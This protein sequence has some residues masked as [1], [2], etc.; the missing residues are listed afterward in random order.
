MAGIGAHQ[1]DLLSGGLP[2]T[3]EKNCSFPIVQCSKRRKNRGVA[4]WFRG[5]HVGLT[6]DTTA[7]IPTW[8]TSPV[9][10]RARSTLESVVD[11]TLTVARAGLCVQ[12][13]TRATRDGALAS[14]LAIATSTPLP[15]RTLAGV[16][17][18][19]LAKKQTRRSHRNPHSLRKRFAIKWTPKQTNQSNPSIKKIIEFNN[20]RYKKLT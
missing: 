8:L 14:V 2:V 6:R 16:V 12:S 5:I 18:R 11:I 10:L 9:G 3:T 20:Q 1:S 4:Y 7:L 15:T 17:L 13:T 19:G